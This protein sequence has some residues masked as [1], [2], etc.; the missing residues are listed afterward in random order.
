MTVSAI[1]LGAN[2]GNYITSGDGKTYTFAELATK[3]DTPVAKG[4]DPFNCFSAPYQQEHSQ[5]L[6]IDS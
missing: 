3:A 2:A 4:I 6:Q 1:V 5:P